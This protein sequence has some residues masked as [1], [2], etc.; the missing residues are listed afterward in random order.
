MKVIKNNYENKSEEKPIK[1]YPRKFTCEFCNSELQYDKEDL[2]AGV[3]GCMFLNC[4]CCNKENA[5]DDEGITLTKCNIEFPTH[6]YHHYKEGIVLDCCNN[7][8]IK[9]CINKAIE[10][11]RDNKNEYIWFTETGNLCI[12]VYREEEDEDYYITVTNNYYSTYIEFES[13]DY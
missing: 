4:P 3:F 7:D 11:F 6:F 13:E 2:I 5:I 12:T 9:K 10:Y 8:E 1:S